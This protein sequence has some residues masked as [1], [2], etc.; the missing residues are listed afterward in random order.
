VKGWQAPTGGA[1]RFSQLPRR[2]Q[3]YV[4]RLEEIVECRF[5]IVS[6]GAGREETIQIADPFKR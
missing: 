4:R 2:A 1:R 6:T 3:E 5:K